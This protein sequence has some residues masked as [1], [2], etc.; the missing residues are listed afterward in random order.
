M[1]RLGMGPGAARL[2]VI[3]GLLIFWEVGVRLFGDPLFMS[4]PSDVA[5]PDVAASPSPTA[6][7]KNRQASSTATLAPT[8]RSTI[9]S[10]A[11][12]RRLYSVNDSG[13]AVGL[14]IACRATA[15]ARARKRMPFCSAR[16]R[17][18][19]RQSTSGSPGAALCKPI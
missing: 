19:A 12:Q 7:S 13:L 8:I 6:A 9:A 14:G 15:S 16:S 18:T 4:P 10:L 2:L 1:S 11:S 17:Q 3:A 5:V